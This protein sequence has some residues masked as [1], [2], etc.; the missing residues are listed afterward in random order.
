MTEDEQKAGEKAV[1]DLTDRYIKLTDG[2]TTKTADGSNATIYR[3]EHI[4]PQGK[5]LVHVALQEDPTQDGQIF[6]C[7]AEAITL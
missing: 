4:L 3:L 7:K 5:Q 6:L 2:I 1:Q